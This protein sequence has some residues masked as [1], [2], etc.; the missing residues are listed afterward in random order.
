MPEPPVSSA[1]VLIETVFY[2]MSTSVKAVLCTLAHAVSSLHHHGC[3]C[4]AEWSTDHGQR[5]SH[6]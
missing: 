6:Q 3:W 5:H 2:H 1:H 4:L